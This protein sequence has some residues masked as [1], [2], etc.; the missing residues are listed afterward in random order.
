MYRRLTY[1]I[2]IHKQIQSVYVESC[3]QYGACLPSRTLLVLILP[4]Q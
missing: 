4:T 2:W 3:V 1:T